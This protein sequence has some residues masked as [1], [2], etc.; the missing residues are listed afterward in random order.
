MRE[1][2]NDEYKDKFLMFKKEIDYRLNE[3]KNNVF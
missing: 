1:T 2:L 3:S